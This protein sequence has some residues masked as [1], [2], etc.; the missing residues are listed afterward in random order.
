MT[1]DIDRELSRRFADLA[2]SDEETAPGFDW[3]RGRTSRLVHSP[4]P[5]G[6]RVAAV[7]AALSIAALALT[8]V[9]W[10][11]RTRRHEPHKAS[12]ATPVSIASISAWRSPTSALLETPGL[13]LL[14]STPELGAP[15]DFPTSPV[16]AAPTAP[17]SPP[18]G[19]AS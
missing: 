14:Q 7:A 2:R 15:K 16:P 19:A 17:P 11:Q 4:V 13:D 3:L 1:D 6:P 8:S 9:L 12:I 18:K 5:A 10:I